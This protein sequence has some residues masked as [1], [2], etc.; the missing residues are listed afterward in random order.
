MTICVSCKVFQP[1]VLQAPAGLAVFRYRFFLRFNL[2]TL[3]NS[4]LAE[5]ASPNRLIA[6]VLVSFSVRI[7]AGDLRQVVPGDHLYAP[8]VQEKSMNITS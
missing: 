2:I 8:E 4:S 7:S 6:I 5:S 3:Q 1:R